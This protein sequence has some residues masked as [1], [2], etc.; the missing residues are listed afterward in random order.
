MCPSKRPLIL[1][2]IKEE[3][4]KKFDD[5]VN[6]LFKEHLGCTLIA[7]FSTEKAKSCILTGA[8]GYR[9][10]EYPNGIDVDD[11][12][13]LASL[14]PQERGQLWT[15]SEVMYGN[16]E[17]DRKPVKTF[18][19]EINKYPG[20]LK[21]VMGI[22]GL[23]K[24]RGSHASGVILFDKDPCEFGA[25]MKTP[26]GEVI[27]QFDLHESEALGMTKFDF[28]LTD[29]QDILVETIKLLQKDKVIEPE[30]TIKEVYDKY[31]HPDALPMQ[32]KKLWDALNSGTILNVFQFDSPIGAD[33]IKKI[34]P[35]DIIE[36]SSANGLMR[37][38]T[39]EKGQ[40]TPMEKYIRFKN[41]MGSWE[42]EMNRFGLTKQEQEVFRKYI[43]NTY[44]IGISQEQL[45]K[46]L[47][48]SEICNFSLADANMARKIIAK[49]LAF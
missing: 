33:A 4:G 36:L 41:V 43:G 30:L 24:Q 9:S 49:F 32:D 12:L 44:G 35:R 13:Y 2:K 18:I 26:S 45:M 40:E 19:N 17:K 28:L 46:A 27:T 29:I 25:F 20:L 15:L 48:G 1:Q 6:S 23:I 34:Q 22:E 16:V 10:E 47:M 5:E 31:L 37:L 38:M 14:I 42:N 7:T 3:R 21:I 8:R 39:N 11:A